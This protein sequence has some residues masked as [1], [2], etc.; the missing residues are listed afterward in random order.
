MGFLDFWKNVFSS[1]EAD[2]ATLRAARA[3]HGIKVD[4][5]I[6]IKTKVEEPEREPYDPWEEV[7]NARMS[8]FFGRWASKKFR[9]VGEDKVKAEL[10]ALEKRRE[11]EKRR[12]GE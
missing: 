9:V 7:S 6:D 5:K 4:E 12:R 10:E 8:F 11:E 2:E 3:R 1:D